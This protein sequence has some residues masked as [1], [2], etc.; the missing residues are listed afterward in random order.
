MTGRVYYQ[1]NLDKLKGE[2]EKWLKREQ[3]Q[4]KVLGDLDTIFL[5]FFLFFPL[6]DFLQFMKQIVSSSVF[7][8]PCDCLH[9]LAKKKKKTMVCLFYPN[10]LVCIEV[11][12]LGSLGWKLH[13]WPEIELGPCYYYYCY[14]FLPEIS[15]TIEV[16]CFG[17]CWLWDRS[18]TLAPFKPNICPVV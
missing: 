11:Y 3:S 1:E 2:N 16:Y 12:I 17:G 14:Y 15:V 13:F 9:H 7:S 18:T 6:C 5:S 4:Q 8:C 10:T